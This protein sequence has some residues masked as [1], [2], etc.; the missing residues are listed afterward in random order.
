MTN[1][2]LAKAIK[3]GDS[4]LVP[5]LWEHIRKFVV[6][7]ANRY[8]M[9]LS[10]ERQNHT[11]V[12]DLIQSGYFGFLNAIEYYDPQKPYKFVTYMENNLK[13]AFAKEVGL[14]YGHGRTDAAFTA[15]HLEEPANSQED[16]SLTLLNTITAVA[17]SGTID[18]AIEN[19]F[20]MELRNVL[21]LSLIHI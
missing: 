11:S 4:G 7:Q 1:E 13:N 20:N 21:E 6:V 3:Q 18:Q 5:E 16:D 9:S 12:D 14:R 17:T 19:V 15:R 10:E 2:E 8:F